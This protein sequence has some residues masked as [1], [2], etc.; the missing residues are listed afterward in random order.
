MLQKADS[1]AHILEKSLAAPSE[2]LREITAISSVFR[3]GKIGWAD[4]PD[5]SH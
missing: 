1:Y 5:S 2:I 4:F 3:T